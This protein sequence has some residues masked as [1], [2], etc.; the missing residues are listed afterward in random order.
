MQPVE[1]HPQPRPPTMTPYVPM[2]TPPSS[3]SA[4]P[5]T[6]YTPSVSS[7]NVPTTS[8]QQPVKDVPVGPPPSTGLGGAWN[9]PPMLKKQKPVCVGPAHTLD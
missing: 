6:M 1:P 7:Y 9:D 3:S 5:P 4:L 2:V 8:Y